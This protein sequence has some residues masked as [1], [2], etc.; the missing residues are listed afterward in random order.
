LGLAATVWSELV[1]AQAVAR[2]MVG[3]KLVRFRKMAT[4]PHALLREDEG[5]LTICV[6][7]KE[8]PPEGVDKLR[9]RRRLGATG[10]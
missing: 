9:P 7:C 4:V 10:S 8:L 2:R 5:I 1:V 6:E 3:A